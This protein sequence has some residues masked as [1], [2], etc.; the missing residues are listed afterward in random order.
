MWDALLKP[1]TT[2]TAG[3]TVFRDAFIAV[4]SIVAVL[5]TLGVL[6]P[7]Q[8]EALRQAVDN[9]SG[10]WPQIV[11]A[12][13][14]VGAAGMSIYRALYKSSSDKA[15]EAAHQIDTQLAPAEPV[16]IKT[17]SGQPDITVGVTATGAVKK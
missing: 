5:G 9:I 2:A 13:G 6:G 3:G 16:V 1:F 12:L 17:P 8:V 7:E 4:S 15:A 14:A 10:Q 11:T